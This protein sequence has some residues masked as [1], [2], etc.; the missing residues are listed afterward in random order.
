MNEK[1][2]VSIQQAVCIIILFILGSTVILGLSTNAGQDAW[3]S[4]LIAVVMMVPLFL[5]Y[6]RIMRLYPET[7]FYD[8]L[9]LLFGNIAGKILIA[10]M[11]WYALHLCALVLRNFS[12]FIQIVM[13]P[14]TPQLPLMIA[15]LLVTCYLARSRASTMG[16]WAIVMLPVVVAMIILTV[17][18]SASD[19]DFS[20]LLPVFEKDPM[21]LI[22]GAYQIVTFPYAETVLFLC[23][24]NALKRQ[25]SPYKM[26]GYAV[27]ISAVF[28]LTILIRNIT[29]LGAPMVSAEYFPSYATARI[30][31]IGNFLTRIEGTITMNF[32]LSG[33]V[34]ITICLTA[35]ARGVARICNIQNHRT[36]ILPTGL[37]ALALCAIVYKSA[38]EM[39][40]FLKYYQIYVVPFQILIPGA[41]WITAEIKAKKRAAA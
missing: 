20:N 34:K 23:M 19:M 8:I 40:G 1:E 31:H 29:I 26:Y 38:M 39:F 4:F 25:D 13:M 5:M 10:V 6:A 21:V 14:E 27:A 41:A 11:A 36:L 16:K 17:F 33:I 30:L 18:L 12:E 24:A 28:L 22:Q 35:A 9:I 7:G 15:M 32:M 37:L 2:T 3:I